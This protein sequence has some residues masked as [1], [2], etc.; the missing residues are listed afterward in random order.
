[1]SIPIQLV[2]GFLGSGKSTFLS[3]YLENNRSKGKIAIIQNEFSPLGIDGKK[4]LQT[5]D[6]EVLEINN[7]SVFCVCLLGSFIDSLSAF[8]EQV[9]PDLLVMESSGL[10]D[11]IGV[12][13]VFQS[14]K[15]KGKVFLDHVWCV[16]DAQNYRRVPSLRLRFQHQIRSADTVIV[17]KTD[18]L[19][20]NINSIVSEIKKINPFSRVVAAQF[21]KVDL[22]NVRKAL[23]IFPDSDKK[24][25]CRP[26]I[27]SV[28]IR[29]SREIQKEALEEFL[30]IHC[31]KSIRCKGFI[32]LKSSNFAFIQGVFEDIRI[33]KTEPFMGP[34]EF[35]LIGNFNK[36]ENLQILFEEYC[37]R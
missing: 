23:N 13:Q 29:S 12:G 22:G 3:Y 17:N 19:K 15:L 10:S 24:P 6:Y 8:T 5:N 26:D 21:G 25:L 36:K 27:E 32:K 7:G 2:T 9:K 14:E 16:V 33:E 28:V 20:E 1:M 37:K 34:T 11:T 4:L 31:S 18:L 35:I 30:K